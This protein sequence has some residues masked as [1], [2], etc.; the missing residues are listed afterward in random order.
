[1]PMAAD[2]AT[3]SA[4]LRDRRFGREDP[5]PPDRPAHQ[6]DFWAVENHSMLEL[7]PPRHTRLR[8]QVL[9]AFTSRRIAALGPE[10]AALA[11]E[12]VDAFPSEPFDLLDAFARPLPVRVIAR[13]LGVPE[14]DAPSLLAWSNAM[15]GMYQARRTHADEVAA[16]RAAAEFTSY[17]TDMFRAP[18]PNGLIAQLLAVEAENKLSRDET[19]ATCILLLNAGH[20][21][22]VHTLGNGVAGLC[23]ADLWGAEVTPNLVEE[24]LRH[25]PPLHLFTRFAME[26]VE[27]HGHQFARGDRVGLLL[28]AAN[29]DPDVY[30]DPA[31]F[32]PDRYPAAPASVSFGAGLHFC[33]GAPLARLE[34]LEA[35]RILA[36]RCPD[37]RVVEPPRYANIYHF[38]GLERLQVDVS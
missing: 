38:H 24:V 19:C 10:I 5:V 7:E 4:L 17:L 26:D 25:D 28:A 20:E 11:H 9:R 29:R 32:I 37:L 15:V 16:A 27:A 33:L 1:M 3:V 8:A 2:H 36:Q 34:L 31:R 6:A 21:A 23:A 22:T 35:L 30:S 13:L 18:A 12:L 14:A